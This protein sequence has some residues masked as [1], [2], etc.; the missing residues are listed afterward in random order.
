M[1]EE[2]ED[3]VEPPSQEREPRD[4][5]MQDA[6]VLGANLSYLQYAGDS[7]ENIGSIQGDGILFSL[8]NAESILVNT[9]TLPGV[10]KDMRNL[11]E[12]IYHK[13][14]EEVSTTAIDNQMGNHLNQQAK[15]WTDILHREMSEQSKITIPNNGFLDWDIIIDHP[16]SLFEREVW[17]TLDAGPKQDITEAC[18]A[19][20]IGC[21]TASVM[22]SLRAVEHYLRKWYESET[23]GDLDRGTW[24][25]VLDDLIN[26]YLEEQD[27]GGP[28]LQQLSGV[29]DILSNLYYL[30]QKRD[31]VS[32]P[33]QSPTPYEAVV[34]LFMVVGT[35]SEVSKEIDGLNLD[36][37]ISDTADL[38]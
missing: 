4:L 30:K 23:G 11:L 32:H 2:G 14:E 22:V 26:L 15:T 7:N 6:Y 38:G 12:Q 27:R 16:Y 35:I 36:K 29:P 21:T 17:E 13:Y 24:G 5:S 37:E 34:T 28:V 8:Y 9:N 10:A 18:R 3:Q 20:P 33:D 1:S 31:Q 25:S 19:L